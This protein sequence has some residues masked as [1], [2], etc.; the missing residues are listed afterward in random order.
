M[1]NPCQFSK[2][3][4]IFEFYG[5]RNQLVKTNEECGELIVAVSKLQQKCSEK[6]I[7]NVKEEIA[8]VVIMSFQ[9]ALDLG[10]DDISSIIEKKIERTIE[11]M[12]CYDKEKN[13]QG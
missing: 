10:I 7:A 9:L 13:Q 4:R 2:L 5:L 3:K 8:D 6:N 12:E 11:R 1:I